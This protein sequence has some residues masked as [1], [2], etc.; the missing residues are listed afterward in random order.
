MCCSDAALLRWQCKRFFHQELVPRHSRKFHWVAAWHAVQRRPSAL[1]RLLQRALCDLHHRQFHRVFP[2]AATATRVEISHQHHAA[3]PGHS[4]PS[5]K[6]NFHTRFM[7]TPCKLSVRF[8]ITN[9]KL[10]NPSYSRCLQCG[11]IFKRNYYFV[12]LNSN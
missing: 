10:N 4:R 1:S 7:F 2:F 3:P 11:Y 12:V 5:G 9:K 8:Y 6:R